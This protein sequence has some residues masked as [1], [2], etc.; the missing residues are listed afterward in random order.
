MDTPDRHDDQLPSLPPPAP[1]TPVPASR[2]VWEEPA[3]ASGEPPPVKMFNLRTVVRAARRHWWQILLLWL[4][5]S[6]A[7]VFLIY[8]KVK[9]KYDTEAWL[10]VKPTSR[11]LIAPTYASADFGPF[12]ETQVLLVKSPDVLGAALQD[13]AV[14]S[15]PRIINSLDPEADLKREIMVASQPKTHL[16]L[17]QMSTET[18][19]EGQ[20]IVNAVVTNYIKAARTWTDDESRIQIDR[21]SDLRKKF[22][23]EV[24]RLQGDLH[25]WMRKRGDAEANVKDR[26]LITLEEYRRYKSRLAD[27]RIE[28]IKAEGTLAFLQQDIK[29]LGQVRGSSAGLGSPDGL[30]EA[31]KA[32]F[33]EHPAVAR[34]LA[35]MEQVRD[36]M[37]KAERLVRDPKNDPSTRRYRQELEK[38]QA[39]Y[40]QLW[41]RMYPTLRARLSQQPDDGNEVVASQKAALQEA[42]LRVSQYKTE[43]SEI[44]TILDKME[45]ENREAGDV[46]LEIEFLKEKLAYNQKLLESVS[47]NLAQA[48]YDAHAQTTINVIAEAQASKAPKTDTRT[49]LMAAAPFGVLVL[50]LGLFT[51]IEI[52]SG[53]VADPDDLPSRVRVGVIGV[54]PPLPALRPSK[55]QRGI[56][57][58][59]RRVEEFVQSLDHLRVT[60]YANRPDGS[61]RRCILIT[62]AIGG[63][64]KTTLAAQLAGRCANAGL[65]TLLVD[66]DLRRPS[67]GDLLEVAEGPGLA[68]VLADEAPAESSMV[69]IGNAGGFHLLPAGAPGYDPS[70][71]LQ[72]E[73]LGQLIAQFRA[74]FDVVIIDAPPVLAVPDALLLGRWTDGAVLAV[75]HDTSRFPLVERAHRRLAAVGIPVLGAVV[76]GVRT[77]ETNYGAYQYNPYAGRGV[78]PDSST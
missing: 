61:Q 45:I 57:D 50:L 46:A 75:R 43:E 24:E 11:N 8:T 13:P 63:E 33:Q 14:A 78:D 47:N 73:K 76:N 60:L 40:N 3:D 69:V 51:L 54:V 35:D 68:E 59:R 70:R 77:M 16:I 4:A 71:L 25:T 21:L 5:T 15:L 23:G 53:R 9:P 30:D 72:G 56:R 34:L 48:E 31:I 52:R 64:G 36:T 28:R 2:V 27:V 58:D 65:L 17:V 19:S 29:R 55:T 49:K 32:Q 67:L 41:N 18:P 6:A 20:A 66:A 38:L 62:S 74:T 37:E 22:Q 42:Q 1:L 7:L 44:Q 39:S 26:N 10:E 12:L